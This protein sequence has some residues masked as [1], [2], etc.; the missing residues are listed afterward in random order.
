MAKELNYEAAMKQLNEIVTKMES[1]ELDLGTLQSQLK[2]AQG[3]LQ[4]CK[5]KLTKTEAE[6]KAMMEEK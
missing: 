3:L 5:D 1:G 6:I 2:T 4:V